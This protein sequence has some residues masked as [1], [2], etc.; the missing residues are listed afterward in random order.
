MRLAVVGSG[1]SGLA[2]A[3]LLQ[4]RHEVHLFERDSRLGGHTHTVDHGDGSGTIS[5]D[6]G[7]FVFNHVTY[8]PPQVLEVLVV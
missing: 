3:W 1:V 6:T 4:R 8:S 7:I 5:L 2:A